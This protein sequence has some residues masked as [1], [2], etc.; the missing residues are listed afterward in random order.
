VEQFIIGIREHPMFGYVPVPLIVGNCNNE[1]CKI[2]RTVVFQDIIDSPDEYTQL[3]K[4]VVSICDNYSDEKIYS[5][6][7]TNKKYSIT[8]FLSNID[9]DVVE[10]MIRPYIE[11]HIAHLFNIVKETEIE[12]Y[13]KPYRYEY[14]YKSD[15]IIISPKKAKA[16]FHFERN[17]EGIKYYLTVYH[18]NHE[19]QIYKKKPIILLNKPA[20][21]EL[22]HVLMYIERIDA[23]KLRPFYNKEYV[24][25]PK[26]MELKY[27]E[28]FVLKTIR[29]NEVKAK[30]FEIENLG[31]DKKALLYIENDW[32]GEY[33][34]IPK[35]RYNDRYFN[36]GDN[37][38]NF[39]EFD[40]KTFKITKF[41]R[42][43]EWE[44]S[45][46]NYLINMD[47][48]Q[49]NDNVFKVPY[50][51][52]NKEEQHDLTIN[53]LNKN[54]KRI[55]E[56][57]F[58]IIQRFTSKKYFIKEM[59]LDLIVDN[60]IDW[61][62][63]QAIVRFG[64]YEIPFYKLK[65]YILNDKHEFELPNGE[66]A[67]IP[68]VWFKKYKNIF[69]F[70]KRTKNNHLRLDKI[71]Y[72]ALQDTGTESLEVQDVRKLDE[73]FSNPHKNGISLPTKLRTKLRDYQKIGFS[74][75]IQ[76]KKNNF[77]ACLA[78]DMGLGKTLQIL[79][80]ILKTLEDAGQITKESGYDTNSEHILNLVIV[81]RS[82]LHNWLN[83]INK[84]TPA[85]R[86]MIYAGTEREKL[87]KM[88]AKKDIIITSYGI[89]RND[90]DFLLDFEFEYIVL[91][92]S[93]Y[94][95]NPNSKTYMA[96]K[97]LKGKN[98]IVLTGTPIENSLR[99]LWTQLN[100]VNKGMLGSYKFFRE[101]YISPIEKNNDEE[102]KI[103]LKKLIAPFILRRTKED[104]VKDLPDI[105]EQTIIC[106]MTDE[107]KM[108]YDTEKS[109][110]RNKI[111][112]F[113][114]KGKLRQSSIYVLQALSKL[115]QIANHPRMLD[116]DVDSGK[117][118]EIFSRLEILLEQNHKVLI[119]SNFVK[120]LN[121]FK[122]EFEKRKWKYEMI[123]GETS[124]RQK[125][126]DHFQT[127]EEIKLFLISIKAG[128]VGI[129][130]TAADYVFIIDPW[131]NPAVEKQAIARAHRIG[132]T[133]NVFAFK[134]IT[135]G[136]VEEKIQLLQK[137]KLDLAHEFIDT[138][139]YFKYFTEEAIIELFD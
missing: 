57:G 117:F 25:V 97:H 40:K 121:L 89:A 72:F 122:S 102:V 127:D 65:D 93:Q 5:F 51:G 62:D 21:I 126:I 42:D 66:I 15:K 71:H 82:L 74:W 48:L 106:E 10:K 86:A 46:I 125:R 43:I 80:A 99:D 64:D 120:Y 101:N 81:P 20:L 77:G 105:E 90:L 110:I 59:N 113:Y 34:I 41:S 104:V 1:F 33:V 98:K 6:F 109:K 28:T 114:H 128:G 108:L 11:K 69:R 75:L 63:I 37:V 135:F 35:F 60:K 16:V 111:I 118:D 53:W 44:M 119:F 4:E 67:I 139:N 107:Q 49:T 23:N 129:N 78:D 30:G 83:E 18:N 24:Q 84:N 19:I 124:N 7:N 100:F 91:D 50:T 137:K 92:E 12:F 112:E 116:M 38:N 39:V 31:S 32:L 103:E 94:I 130:L 8:D 52:K 61:F 29:D 36:V 138:N 9:K 17:E 73:F 22:E 87:H 55:E 136:T 27:F 70:S 54:Y 131:W 133:K 58:E 26:S 85:M 68:E 3:Q 47:L 134:F 96:L 45:Y 56:F 88:F 95:K 14:I 79:T 115:R 132:Q 76:L 123:T 13:Y 2:I